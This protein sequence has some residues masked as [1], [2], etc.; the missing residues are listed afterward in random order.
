MLPVTCA[1]LIAGAAGVIALPMAKLVESAGPQ[2]MAA[3]VILSG[4]LVLF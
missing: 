1:G 4:R 3:A 2:Y